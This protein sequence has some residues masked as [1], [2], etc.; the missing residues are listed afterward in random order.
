MAD[1]KQ[2]IR[3]CQENGTVLISEDVIA[4]IAAQAISDV[5]GVVGMSVKPNTDLAEVISKKAWG[6][7]LRI[8][9]GQDDELY[10][11]CNVIIAYGQSVVS[12]AQAVQES[13]TG[14]LESMTGVKVATVNVNVSGIARQ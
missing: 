13:V 11:D 10:V 6:K 9:I 5:D 12:V 8:S 3:Q 7:S 1:N 2:Y 4:T 14:A